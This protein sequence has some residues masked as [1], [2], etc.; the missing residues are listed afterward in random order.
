MYSVSSREKKHLTTQ[1][2]S[3]QTP[4]KRMIVHLVPVVALHGRLCMITI[5]GYRCKEEFMVID[6][7]RFALMLP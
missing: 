3:E 5:L 7:Y 1:L 2:F 6:L 4:L